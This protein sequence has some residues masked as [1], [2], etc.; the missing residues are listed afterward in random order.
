MAT[1]LRRVTVMGPKEKWKL[2]VEDDQKLK[3]ERKRGKSS[4]IGSQES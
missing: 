1:I 2:L 4:V 3:A